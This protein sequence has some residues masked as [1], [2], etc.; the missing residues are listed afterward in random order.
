MDLD[1]LTWFAAEAPRFAIQLGR[2]LLEMPER[3]QLPKGDGHPIIFLPGF[4]TGNG[5]TFFMRRILREQQHNALRWIHGTNVGITEEMVEGVVD[6]VIRV[7][8]DYGARV[9]LVGQ[10]L[11]G[12]IA[13]VVAN[14]VPNN[15]R[16]VVTLGSPINGLGGILDNVKTMYDARTTGAGAEEAWASYYEHIVD[17]PP[18][19]STSIYSKTDGVV[20]WD[21]SIMIET[22]NA[23]NVEVCSSH[24]SMGFDIDV[25]KVI[26]D[27][28][29][30]PEGVWQRYQ[31]VNDMNMDKTTGV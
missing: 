23:E 13:R 1:R 15:V 16:S 18:L 2:T 28:L 25:I 21:E 6:Q 14:M 3:H 19:P 9:S 11:G 31:G 7:S 30:Q 17:N 24:L 29:A 12:S 5:A 20:H 22:A 4:M 26:A 10:S 8:N 27:R